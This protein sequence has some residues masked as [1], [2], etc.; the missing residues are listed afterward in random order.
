MAGR[1]RERVWHLD[2]RQARTTHNNSPT[3]TEPTAASTLFEGA[4][5]R[6]MIYTLPIASTDEYPDDASPEESTPTSKLFTDILSSS[7]ITS[8]SSST[9]RRSHT[10]NIPALASLKRSST[11]AASFIRSRGKYFTRPGHSKEPSHDDDSQR[12][13][14]AISPVTIKRSATTTAS[15]TAA[16]MRGMVKPSIEPIDGT[17]MYN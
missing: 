17:Y 15:A 8:A 7:Q 12:S 1:T 16:Y 6:A 5:R 11:T 2:S 9:L 13:P 14:P 3:T 4:H 10:I